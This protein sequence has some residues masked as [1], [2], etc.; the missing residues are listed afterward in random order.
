LLE[1]FNFNKLQ[2]ELHWFI[3][4]L[5]E[6]IRSL[7]ITNL[8]PLEEIQQ[9]SQTKIADVAEKFIQ[10][11]GELLQRENKT[12]EENEALQQRIRQ[13][14]PYFL[15][16]IQKELT[17]PLEAFAVETDSREVRKNIEKSEERLNSEINL[18][19]ACL[20]ACRHGFLLSDYLREKAKASLESLNK[21]SGKKQQKVI[22]NDEIKNPG[23]YNRLKRWRN[24]KSSELGISVF[25]VLPLKT[26]RALS[27]YVPSTWEDMVLIPG[28]GK[29]KLER[30]GQ[31]ILD[32]LNTYREDHSVEAEPLLRKKTAVPPPKKP[33][34]EISLELWR[35]HRDIQMVAQERGLVVSTI[36]GHLAHYV[37]T[38]DL[39][40]EDFVEKDKL[41]QICT[42]MNEQPDA[43]IGEAK[44]AMGDGYTYAEL[45]FVHQH[46]KLQGNDDG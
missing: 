25:M 22:V 1:L 20:N 43:S 29:K 10:Q 11:I 14:V 2:K 8:A 28:L 24:A 12:A 13:A 23:L 16:H 46:L 15:E 27:N 17:D 45:R 39:A 42:F 21:R 9:K 6:N 36:E 37:G 30:F 31:E 38:G 32:L 35:K 7:S 18:K 44:N 3:R 34:R 19:V 33:T 26:I 5:R 4:L 40:V 41:D